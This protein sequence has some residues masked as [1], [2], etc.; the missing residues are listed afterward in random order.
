MSVE[1]AGPLP[2]WPTVRAWRKATRAR[3]RSMR[4]RAAFAATSALRAAPEWFAGKR[5]G[6]YWPMK[7]ELDLVPFVRSLL[8]DLA[9]A[10]L[11]VIVEK[12]KPLEFWRWTARTELCNRGVW[13]IP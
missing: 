10:A 1:V 8:P 7:G 11:P 3:P 2:D 9:A 13:N 5:L 12:H 4:T 6:F